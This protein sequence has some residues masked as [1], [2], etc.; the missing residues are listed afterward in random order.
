MIRQ[1]VG[2]NKFFSRSVES[3]AIFFPKISA[4]NTEVDFEESIKFSPDTI[5]LKDEQETKPYKIKQKEPTKQQLKKKI[6]HTKNLQKNPN[7][8]FSWN[9]CCKFLLFVLY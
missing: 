2:I 8:Y 7:P 6:T 4:M 1:E 5:I 3:V 9:R